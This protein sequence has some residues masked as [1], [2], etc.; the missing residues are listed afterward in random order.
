MEK[1]STKLALVFLFLFQIV[2][3]DVLINEIC[4]MG[5]NI[6]SSNEWI[7][8]Y[9][10]SSERVNLDGWKIKISEEKIVNLKGTI[11]SQGFYLLS[12]NKNETKADLFY[13]KALNN[14]GEKLDLFDQ[15]NNIVFSVDFSSGWPYGNNETKQTME[16]NPDGW[17]TSLNLGGTPK[18][19]NSLI[20]KD[21]IKTSNTK[22]K[23]KTNNYTLLFSF[24]SSLCFG[25]VVLFVK[26]S[27]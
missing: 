13:S 22:K 6:S 24:F 9:N 2:K 4:W 14:K 18:E 21:V 27:I 1:R 12:R 23:E 5:D 3:A 11:P 19:K 7:E 15:N 20:E 8:L 25:G 10:D 26:K 16:K 17:Q